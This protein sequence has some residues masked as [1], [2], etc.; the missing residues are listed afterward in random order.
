M[1]FSVYL[2]KTRFILCEISSR[3]G[4]KLQFLKRSSLPTEARLELDVCNFRLIVDNLTIRSF[5]Y[6]KSVPKTQQPFGADAIMSTFKSPL[7]G[8][9]LNVMRSNRFPQHISPWSA[10]SFVFIWA[11][12]DASKD[13]TVSRTSRGET[14][15][16]STFVS[17]SE[18][19]SGSGSSDVVLLPC[20]SKQITIETSFDRASD[21]ATFRE[22]VTAVCESSNSL[23]SS[24]VTNEHFA[25]SN[26]LLDVNWRVSSKC[27]LHCTLTKK[28]GH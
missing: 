1:L 7:L 16:Q 5:L 11:D 15:V 19:T 12:T 20:R 21:G 4:Y 24:Q 13:N 2:H 3:R 6:K 26:L 25:Y 28:T 14:R 22:K 17:D 18:D 23:P 27:C 8:Y 10:A 9:T